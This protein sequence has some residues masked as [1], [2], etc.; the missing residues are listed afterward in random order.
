MAKNQ[1]FPNHSLGQHISW[2]LESTAHSSRSTAIS[3]APMWS[4]SNHDYYYYYYFYF[5]P[6]V[7]FRKVWF[8]SF[9]FHMLMTSAPQKWNNNRAIWPLTPTRYKIMQIRLIRFTKY[10]PAHAKIMIMMTIILTVIINYHYHHNEFHYCYILFFFLTN[11]LSL[12]RTKWRTSSR[13]PFLPGFKI[14]KKTRPGY[15]AEKISDPQR[16]FFFF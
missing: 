5:F 1:W 4:I 9:H 15:F 10:D 13:T 2:H 11:P 6:C 7:C 12:C 14:K 3:A 16:S 8:V